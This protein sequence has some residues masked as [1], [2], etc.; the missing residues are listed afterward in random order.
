MDGI[1]MRRE[2]ETHKPLLR[3]NWL[4]CATLCIHPI[5]H[6]KM[7]HMKAD[8]MYLKG[9]LFLLSMLVLCSI[10]SN[11]ADP[12]SSSAP[13]LSATFTNDNLT[14]TWPKSAI[15]WLL[16][17]QTVDGKHWTY[18]PASQYG[19]NATNIYLT[20]RLPVEKTFYRLVEVPPGIRNRLG[21]AVRASPPPAPPVSTNQGTR[22]RPAKAPPAPPPQP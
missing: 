19:T 3:Q 1:W 21:S 11:A 13:T 14:L 9:F 22:P 4:A 12:S 18:V 7:Y 6:Q 15:N 10:T 5:A 2:R 17:T 8:G 16:A 20:V